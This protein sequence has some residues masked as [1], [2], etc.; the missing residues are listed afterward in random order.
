MSTKITNHY[1]KFG[2][3]KYFRGSAH[4][5]ELG[6][7]G[8]KKDPIGAKA[9]LAPHDKIKP[10]HMKGRVKVNTRT[11]IDWNEVS[12]VE[13]QTGGALT[14]YGIN[15]NGAKSFSH[16][17]AKSAKLE[18]ISLSIDEGPLIAMINA[19]RPA[20]NQMADEGKDARIVS[21]VWVVVEAELAEHFKTYGS[22]SAGVEIKAVKGD[23][24]LTVSGGTRGSQSIVLSK[25]TTFAYRLHKVNDWNKGKTRVEGV[26]DDYKG[27][28]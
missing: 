18:L 15:F 19:D 14:Y 16:A 27:M 23:A 9:W 22:S 25:G 13:L 21:E 1:F 5:L 8:Q 24:Q 17:H 10:V 12:S 2:I 26:E 6:H 20:R 7:Y 4:E 28:S 3:H 11:R